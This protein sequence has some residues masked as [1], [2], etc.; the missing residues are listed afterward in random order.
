MISSSYDSRSMNKAAHRASPISES[1]CQGQ[2]TGSE[3]ASAMTGLQWQ[4]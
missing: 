1:N 3:F 4:R 2:A